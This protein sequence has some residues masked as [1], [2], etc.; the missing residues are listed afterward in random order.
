MPLYWKKLVELYGGMDSTIKHLQSVI[1]SIESLIDDSV[2]SFADWS[3]R[4][5]RVNK[6]M[7]TLK[8]YNV[9]N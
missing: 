6:F 3:L 1:K 5:K 7:K 8:F 4:I 2:V 9:N